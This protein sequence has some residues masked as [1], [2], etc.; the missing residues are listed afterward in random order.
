MAGVGVSITRNTVG[1]RLDQ[2]VHA[3]GDLQQ[4]L[5]EIG[6]FAVSEVLAGFDAAADPWGLPWQVSQRAAEQGGKT[7]TDK[8]H[9]RDSY[10]YAVSA[11]GVAVGSNMVYARPHQHGRD[12]VNLP[13]Q[14]QL[15]IREGE[16]ALPPHWVDEVDG[17]LSDHLLGRLQ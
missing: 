5:T 16:V 6:D 8:G 2:L 7:L 12:E 9:L 1:D 3:I 13:A 4:P 11:D 14:P 15:P 17:I 10:T